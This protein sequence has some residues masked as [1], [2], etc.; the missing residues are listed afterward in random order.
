MNSFV[1]KWND[2]GTGKMYIGVH[3]GTPDDG[4]VC[5]SKYMLE[6]YDKRPND[7]IR[8]ILQYGDYKECRLREIELLREVDAVH[9]DL[10]YNR[11]FAQGAISMDK[12]PEHREKLRLANLGK[13]QSEETKAK[14]KLYKHSSEALSKI[15]ATHKGK[16]KSEE[17]RLRMSLAAKGKP[18][19]D[20]HRENNSKAQK[21]VHMNKKRKEE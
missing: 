4:Y 3:K 1:Y 12:T 14:R 10:F 19:S 13:K 7:F 17:T 15:S 11:S 16:P 6:E 5:S 9:N 20:Q 18:K 21:L 8:E 2:I